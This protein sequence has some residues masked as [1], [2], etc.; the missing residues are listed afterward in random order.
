MSTMTVPM[1]YRQASADFDRFILDVRDI[2]GLQTTN[3]AYTMVQAVLQTFRRRLDVPDGLLFA[4]V[5]PPVLR[6]IFVADWDLEEPQM[7]FAGR[8]AMTREVQS[9]R[10]DHNL[11]PDTAIADVAA[12]LRRNVDEAV[13]DRVLARLPAGAAD[14]WRA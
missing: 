12:A 2:A 5:L 4:N 8:F 9:L 3:Q 14:F 11:S 7:P 1:E 6:A 10:P 13:L